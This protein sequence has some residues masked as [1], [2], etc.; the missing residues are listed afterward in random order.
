MYI[1]F[2]CWA[3]CELSLRGLR[4]TPKLWMEHR[5]PWSVLGSPRGPADASVGAGLVTAS[6]QPPC[7]QP[8]QPVSLLLVGLP[9]LYASGSALCSY[10]CFLSTPFLPCV[11]SHFSC[12]QL[13]DSTNC[14]PPGSPVHGILQTRILEWVVMPSSSQRGSLRRRDQTCV[15]YVS[16]IVR[17]VLYTTEP[18]GKPSFPKHICNKAPI[19]Y[20]P[21]YW[22]MK[23]CILRF[24]SRHN[25]EYDKHSPSNPEVYLFKKNTHKTLVFPN[26]GWWVQLHIGKSSN[27][28]FFLIIERT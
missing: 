1:C 5:V 24:Y 28:F 12:V 21:F 18:P 14:S 27:D 23:H 11:L 19:P 4:F 15:F 3:L 26:N 2:R 8:T 22:E 10:S 7:Q 9:G 13:F 25:R 16:C 6:P 20:C 17:Q